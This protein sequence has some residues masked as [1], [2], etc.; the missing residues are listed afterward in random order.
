[1]FVIDPNPVTGFL[2]KRG[3]S[4]GVLRQGKKKSEFKILV[5]IMAYFNWNNIWKILL[6]SLPTKEGYPPLIDAE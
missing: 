6:F 5:L 3:R 4:L 1:M 2:F